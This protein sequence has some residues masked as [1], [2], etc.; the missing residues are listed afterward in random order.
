[1]RLS[2]RERSILSTA[3]LQSNASAQALANETGYR[4][5]SV[6]YV[7][8]RFEQE[9]VIRKR[10][11][12]DLWRI[13]VIQVAVYLSVAF[14]SKYAA[15]HF[16][17][18]LAGS[19]R[20]GDAFEV[21][22][23]FQFSVVVYGRSIWDTS[24]YINSLSAIPG[25]HISRKII[26]VRLSQCL[27]R[28]RYLSSQK[29]SLNKIFIDGTAKQ[30]RL[31]PSD[32]QILQLLSAAGNTSRRELA[33]QLSI[34]HS[35]FETRTKRLVEDGVICG[36]VYGINPDRIG[37]QSYRILVILPSLAPDTIAEMLRFAE[38]Q[39]NVVTIMHCM[40]NF[41]FEVLVEVEHGSDIRTI[42]QE[43]TT[44]F[45]HRGV[46]FLVVPFYKYL[47]VSEYTDMG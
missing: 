6:R 7:L 11:V 3:Q 16:H 39:L 10:P 23:E 46:H 24:H 14:E 37:V 40:G 27:Y 26:G 45:G 21:G 19:K 38:T 8:K 22:A 33:R 17:T 28:R 12:I 36:W 25:T 13:G 47:K 30:L 31:D 43:M 20:I 1:M 42:I 34:P 9:G 32:R 2:E 18:M 44:Q 29:S 4:S 5:H 35:T 15:E 41:D